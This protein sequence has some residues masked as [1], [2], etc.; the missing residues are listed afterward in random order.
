I[1]R[2]TA[3]DPRRDRL[4]AFVAACAAPGL[5]PVR[6]AAGVADC[7]READ[8]IVTATTG[9]REYLE[10]DWLRPGGLIVAL[11]L[12][13]PTRELFLSADKVVVD[14]FDQCNREEKLLHRLVQAGRFTRAQ[15]HAE[16]GEIVT[17][18]RPGRA[19]PG[20]RV[21]VNPMGMAIEDLTLAKAVY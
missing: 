14:D 18:A 5:P 2:F 21:L 6:A 8:V 17:G 4:E 20:E 3:F 9:A 13:D 19:S 11:S 10:R 7:V 1:E 16:L 12:D 15:V